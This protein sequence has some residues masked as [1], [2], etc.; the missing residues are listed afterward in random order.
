MRPKYRQI[1][2]ISLEE[3]IPAVNS[4]SNFREVMRKLG[5]SVTRYQNHCDLR[6]ICSK[7]NI[8]IDNLSPKLTSEK[9]YKNPKFCKYCGKMIPY[10][11]RENDFCCGSC[12]ATYCNITYKDKYD[13]A[14]QKKKRRK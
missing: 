5:C 1:R 13:S 12:S 6:D 3:I 10:E 2:D 11:K 8:P 4:S 14:R 7:N 9:Y